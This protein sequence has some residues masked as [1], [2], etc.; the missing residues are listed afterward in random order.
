VLSQDERKA[1]IKQIDSFL[2]IVPKD[3]KT[4]WLQFRRKLERFNENILAGKF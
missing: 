3:A 2:E 4:F 1:V